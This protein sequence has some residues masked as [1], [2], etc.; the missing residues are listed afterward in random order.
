MAETLFNVSAMSLYKQ[1]PID[2]IKG[3]YYRRKDRNDSGLEY[4]FFSLYN[5][6]IQKY[7]RTVIVNPSPVMVECFE[8]TGNSYQYIVTDETLAQLYAKQYRRS[9]FVSFENADKISGVDM[10]VLFVSNIEENQIQEMMGLINVCKARK[11]CGIIHTRLIDNKKSSFWKNVLEGKLCI[12]EIVITSNN[13][14]VTS[15]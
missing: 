13:M 1:K 2:V 15:T 12:R 5:Q 3:I 7:K 14:S 9:T 10:L 11:I 4:Y 6:E 8:K